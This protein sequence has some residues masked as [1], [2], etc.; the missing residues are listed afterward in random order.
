MLHVQHRAALQLGQVGQHTLGRGTIAQGHAAAL[1]EGAAQR[2]LALDHVQKGTLPDE[3]ILGD[4]RRQG[5][6]EGRKPNVH[7]AAE[8]A[9]VTDTEA[10]YLHHR[11]FDDRYFC[12]LIVDYLRTF[13]SAK[14]QKLNRLLE[15]KL[16]DL[17]TPPQKRNKIDRLLKR[18]Q[19]EA[20]IRVEGNS[21]AAVW[22]LRFP[23][24]TDQKT[25]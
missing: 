23:D 20:K 15:T 4:L 21:K 16:S 19:S 6:I 14:R 12:D 10:E 11:A 5:L 17:L 8:I 1:F 25:Q 7:V 2:V 22:S 9:A 24:S 18:L 3:P 13:G